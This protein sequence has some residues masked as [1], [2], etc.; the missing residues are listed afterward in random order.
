[1]SDSIDRTKL[2]LIFYRF[3]ISRFLT[4]ITMTGYIIFY[5]WLIVSIFH[6]VFLAGMLITI[7]LAIEIGFSFPIGHLIDMFNNTTL[8]FYSNVIMILGFIILLFSGE[9]YFIYAATAISVLGWTIKLDTFSAIIKKHLSEN[10]FKKANSLNNVTNSLSSI[11][12]T[13]MGGVSIILFPNYFKYILLAISTAAAIL[14]VPVPEKS[15]KS[16][17]QIQS[18]VKDV[19]EAGSFIRKISGFLILAFFLNGLFISLDTYSSGLFKI[20]LKS[21]PL[22]YSVFSMSVPIGTIMGT[23]LANV[24]YF[25]KDRPFVISILVLLFSPFLIILSIS[26]SPL[27]DI[28]DALLI[29]MILPIINIPLLTRLMKLVP[30][31]IYGKVMAFL[32]IFTGG[33]S[34]VMGAIFSF[35]VIFASIPIILLYVGI[36]VIPLTLYGIWMIPRFFRLTPEFE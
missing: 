13:I 9:I 32:K 5:S 10:L 8:N 33:A 19:R 29:G 6:S 4:G 18:F 7:T 1:M 11:L 31:S 3:L 27:L 25:R 35:F 21:S 26:K 2:P 20:V 12:G 23:P 15:F 30:R 22:L 16:E 14:S 24:G 28:F 17:G 36:L 34:P